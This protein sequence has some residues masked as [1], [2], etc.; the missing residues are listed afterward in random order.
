MDRETWRKCLL[1]LEPK[2]MGFL[3]LLQGIKKSTNKKIFGKSQVDS[4]TPQMHLVSDHIKKSQE[5][6]YFSLTFCV[7]CVHLNFGTV[8][9]VLQLLGK[10]SKGNPIEKHCNSNL[11]FLLWNCV[12]WLWVSS[13]NFFFL[14]RITLLLFICLICF[15]VS[16]F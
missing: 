9:I 4:R 1:L 5:N 8:H 16:C 7:F 10:F 15:I 14:H 2:R 11:G 13:N 3:G 12:N 6:V